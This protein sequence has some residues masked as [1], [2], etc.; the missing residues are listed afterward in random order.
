MFWKRALP[1]AATSLIVLA[2]LHSAAHAGTYFTDASCGDSSHVTVHWTWYEDPQRPTGHPEWLGYDVLRRSLADCGS[3]VRVNAEPFVR[4]PGA[5]QSYAYTEAPPASHTTFK[6]RVIPVD[7]N[8]QEVSLGAS[9]DLCAEDG[10]AS[11]PDFSAPLTQGTLLDLGW[12]LVVEPCVDGCH[13]S[14]YFSDPRA[15]EL[16]PYAGTDIALRFYGRAACGGVEGCSLEI[17]HYDLMPCGSTPTVRES[18]GHT[19]S[20]YR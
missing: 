17:D 1:A 15:S 11:C 10:W 9:C 5:N 3:F 14:F 19:K 13:D 16:R 18:W 12:A 8:R 2:G 20:V 7:A 6:Y 4:I